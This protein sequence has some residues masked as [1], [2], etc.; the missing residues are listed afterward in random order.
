M[1]SIIEIK[2]LYIWKRNNSQNESFTI[3]IDDSACQ[4]A[5]IKFKISLL[6]RAARRFVH[7]DWQKLTQKFTSNR[8]FDAS[9]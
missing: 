6:R 7:N 9:Y 3:K 1:F 8:I 5:K 2:R 4:V